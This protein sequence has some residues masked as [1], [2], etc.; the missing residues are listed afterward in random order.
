MQE[1]E[2]ILPIPGADGVIKFATILAD[3]RRIESVI[4][5]I[6]G[7]TTVCVSTQV[8]CSRGCLFC[9]T[10]AM[11]FSRNLEVE[12]IVGQ[13]HTGQLQGGRRIDNV[14]FMGMGEPL[15]NFENVVQAIRG[16]A[17]PHG[18]DIA[19]RYITV[20]TAGHA[21]GIRRLGAIK[22]PNLRLAVS[23]NAAD[24]ALRSRL[25]PINRQY[26]LARLKEE[27]L[28][29]PRGKRGVVFVEYVLLAGIND[30]RD[31]A[32]QLARYL[33]GLPVRVNVIPYNGG[34]ESGFAVPAPEQ[35]RRFCGW[36][37]EEKL[38]VRERRSRGQEVMAAC[39]MLKA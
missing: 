25:M 20:S 18:L 2:S 23:I 37:V 12:E 35:V 1:R 32:L 38:F 22:L 4:L 19:Y 14:V 30:S 34:P 16:M 26:P 9:A 21:D 10:G 33:D 6:R 29:F 28:A 13:V 39:G 31:Q 11:G 27:L 3:G 15:D 36:L 8:G 17:D 5:P 7:R 24:D